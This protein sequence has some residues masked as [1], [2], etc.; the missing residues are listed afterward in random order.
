MAL[1]LL[2]RR[3]EAAVGRSGQLELAAGLERDAGAP[4][5]PRQ[6]LSILAVRVLRAARVA[7]QRVEDGA[8]AGLA[9]VGDGLEVAVHHA[10]LLVLDP[11]LPF[12]ARLLGAPEI[13]DQLRLAGHRL[14]EP[15]RAFQ[16]EGHVGEM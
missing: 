3:A 5:G 7:R 6:W 4:L 8:D 16:V 12:A 2:A 1:D 14:G 10:D 9:V 13:I 15:G 11:D